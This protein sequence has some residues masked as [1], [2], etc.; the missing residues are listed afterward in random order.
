MQAEPSA[1]RNPVAIGFAQ[2]SRTNRHLSLA[3]EPDARSE[4]LRYGH[5][6]RS[7]VGFSEDLV[8]VVVVVGLGA[9]WLLEPVSFHSVTGMVSW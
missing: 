2:S 8:A 4:M 7:L 3:R 5:G 1:Q 9:Y 6:K